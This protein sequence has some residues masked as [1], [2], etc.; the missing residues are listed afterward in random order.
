M[1]IHGDCL[2][3]MQEMEDNSISAIVT[4]PPYGLKFMGKDW[5]HGIPGI[6]Y[7]KET[8]R[9]SKP[10]SFML[11]FGGTRTFH[12]LTCSIE[13]AGWEIR[14]CIM[15][16]YGSGFPKGKGCLKPA[17]EPIIMARKNGPNPKLNIDE[18]RIDILKC[19]DIY[20]KN[21]HTNHKDL[22]SYCGNL[23]KSTYCI[24]QG[25]W[26]S[27]LLLD[28]ESAALLDQQSGISRS[29]DG[30]KSGSNANPMSWTEDNKD[31]PRKA[32]NDSGG[33]SRFFYCAKASSS[34]RN[35]GCEDLPIKLSPYSQEI[36]NGEGLRI[37]NRV[38]SPR[39]NNHPTVKPVKL[40]EYLI[41]LIMPPKDGLLLDPFA[42]SGT[43]LLAAQN[44]GFKA[45]GIEK[46][47]GYCQI[48]KSR[49][50]YNSK[51]DMINLEQEIEPMA[52]SR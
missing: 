24:P 52:Q 33:A 48:A 19:D 30:G 32:P 20:K 47:E 21:P 42:G 11:A 44:L 1:I 36:G 14:D 17:W 23:G 2:L 4:D 37:K 12:R 26:P 10:G 8:L 41:K 27:N 50:G 3:K 25:R 7:W 22:N 18:C 35:F 38:S 39:S 28:E 51:N 29:R 45:I 46:D 34:E 9:I 43:T 15:W 5:D 31:R 16:L 6:P 40:M 13:D 49:L